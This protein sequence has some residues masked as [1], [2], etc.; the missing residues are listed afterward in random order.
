MKNLFGTVLLSLLFVI[1]YSRKTEYSRVTVLSLES[2]FSPEEILLYFNQAEEAAKRHQPLWDMNIYG[3][4]LLVDPRTRALY[5]NV[6]DKENVLVL[7]EGVYRGVLPL[8]VPV[9]NTDITWNGVHWAMLELPLPANRYDRVDL[10]THEL[11]HVAQEELGLK[12]RREDNNHLGQKDGRVYLRLEL[13]ALEAAL[14]AGRYQR[15]EE[16]LRNALI[17]RKYRHLIYRGAQLTENSLEIL[18]GLATYTGQMMSGRDKWEWRNYLINRISQYK[19]TPTYVRSFAYETTPVYGYF[20]QQKDYYWNKKVDGDTDLT[21]LF[22]DAFGMDTRIL[23][24]SYVRQVAKEYN[25]GEIEDDESKL[26]IANDS[27]VD[28]YRQKFFDLPHLEIRLENMNMSFDPRNLIPMDED[29]GTVYPTIRLSDNWGILTVERGGALLRPDWRW[30]IVSEPLEIT[31][32]T[33]M[34]DGWVIN[35]NEGYFLEE[36]LQGNYIMSKRIV[37]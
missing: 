4:I 37:P 5:A 18:E 10:M 12:L 30:I 25:V 7:K 24:Q 17:F 29:E 14:K 22:S 19:D 11:F 3:P 2:D 15:S 21:D 27:L 16:H 13:A 36:T 34:G 9:S 28:E 26:S 8:E 33:I 1:A 23:L 35:L 31:G 20:M 6:P 32:E